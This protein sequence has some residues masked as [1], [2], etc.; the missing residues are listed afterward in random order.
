MP[1]SAAQEPRQSRVAAFFLRGIAALL[2][3][4][5]TAFVFITIFRFANDYVTRPI[6]RVIYW[7]L[8]S[9]ALGWKLLE[10]LGVDPYAAGMI[11]RDDLPPALHDIADRHG[12]A[13][14]ELMTALQVERAAHAGFWRDLEAL[15]VDALRL[16]ARVEDL[17]HPLIGAVLSL[18]LV[19]WVGWLVTSLLGRLVIARIERGLL[20]M[21]GVRAVY[22]YSKQLVEF[23]FQED[24]RKNLEFQSVVAVRYPS[25]HVWSYGFLTNRAPR[26]LQQATGQE[27]VSVFIPSTPL[28][29]SGFTI[30]VPQSELIVLQISVDDALKLIVTGGVILPPHE[31]ATQPALPKAPLAGA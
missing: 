25:P 14:S 9:N 5:L 7:S 8:E 16:R 15:H 20:S 27:L 21:P 6:N 10:G 22:P 31:L 4:A 28:P 24:K 26:S 13:S 3:V 30:N 19:L 12:I 2:P 18:M 11:A 17:V 29:M 23:F 1:D